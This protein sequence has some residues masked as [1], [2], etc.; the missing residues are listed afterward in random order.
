VRKTTRGI[1]MEGQL[2][3]AL[4]AMRSGRPIREVGRA[5]SI[6]KSTIRLRLKTGCTKSTQE[7]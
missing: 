4:N 1:S 7:D 5:F 2:E 6:T 3:A